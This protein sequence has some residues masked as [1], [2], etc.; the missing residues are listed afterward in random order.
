MNRFTF[1]LEK[2]EEYDLLVAY[3]EDKI[4]EKYFT[5]DNIDIEQCIY[6]NHLDPK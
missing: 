6:I 4:G 3:L 2:F 5:R 1:F